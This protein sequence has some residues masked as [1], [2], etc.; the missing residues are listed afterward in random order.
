MR[1]LLAYHSSLAG[2]NLPPIRW[3]NH[4]ERARVRAEG[5]IQILRTPS[6][7]ADL[8][9]L[10]ATGWLALCIV[11]STA[12]LR[13]CYYALATQL[14]HWNK[15]SRAQFDNGAAVHAARCAGGAPVR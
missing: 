13:H 6:P 11:C 2:K 15:T 4:H 12:H 10:L 8:L 3:Q 7:A 1:V 5:S 14:H 9:R